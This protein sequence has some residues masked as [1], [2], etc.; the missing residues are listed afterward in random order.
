MSRPGMAALLSFLIPGVGQIYNG[1]ILRGVFWLIVTPGF[2]IGTGGML[3]WLCHIIAAA[4]AFNRA[5]A[6]EKQRFGIA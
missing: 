3:G 4:T 2:W 1:D 5:E 6:R